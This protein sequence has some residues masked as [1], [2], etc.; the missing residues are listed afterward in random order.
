MRTSL[1]LSCVQDFDALKL[2]G[3]VTRETNGV[4]VEGVLQTGLRNDFDNE[5]S[6]ARGRTAVVCDVW[7]SIGKSRIHLSNAIPG[8]CASSLTS[9]RG[10]CN[11]A[12]N[13]LTSSTSGSRFS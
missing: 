4:A 13:A 1:Q 3:S 12:S 10:G 8:T 11:L 9:T 5:E 2:V 6:L 7:G